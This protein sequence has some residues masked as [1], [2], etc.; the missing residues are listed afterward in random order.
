MAPSYPTS[1]VPVIPLS[2]DDVVVHPAA[3]EALG[4]YRRYG[5]NRRIKREPRHLAPPVLEFVCVDS[6]EHN[7]GEESQD[8][9]RFMENRRLVGGFDRIAFLP[10]AAKAEFR[11]VDQNLTGHGEIEEYA[12][13]HVL[14]ACSPSRTDNKAAAAFLIDLI[15]RFP[16]RLVDRLLPKDPQSSN[17]TKLSIESLCRAF[18][19]SS[20]SVRRYVVG[21]RRGGIDGHSY[22]RDIA[23][24]GP[25][26]E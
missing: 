11:I 20:D 21:V 12:W 3:V 7:D 24:G 4:F 2:V 23:K 14:L 25:N 18:G 8:A 17:G 19:L 1:R 13:Q 9:S 6:G 26:G 5:M 10:S 15:E 22:G 16:K